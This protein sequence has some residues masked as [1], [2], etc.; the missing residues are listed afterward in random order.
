MRRRY[1]VLCAVLS[2]VLPVAALS[3]P[4]AATDV[5]TGILTTAR[6]TIT[7]TA[8]VP[9]GSELSGTTE[10]DP[11]NTT[12]VQGDA[13]P[14]AVDVL[15]EGG[16]KATSASVAF[17][18]PKGTTFHDGFYYGNDVYGVRGLGN[19]GEASS[20]CQYAS[21]TVADVAYSGSTLTR[22]DI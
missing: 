15:V 18:A 9:S 11:T 3:A 21:F 5:N 4:A 14:S 7:S 10:F 6:L 19:V 2:V 8:T 17:T 1:I 16:T 12:L 13:S 20:G 22:L